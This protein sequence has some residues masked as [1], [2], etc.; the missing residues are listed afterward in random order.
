MNI[1][2]VLVPLDYSACSMGVVRQASGLAQKLGAQVTLLHVAELPPGVTTATPV[3]PHGA[4]ASVGEVLQRDADAHLLRV[5]AAVRA[6]GVDCLA[7]VRFGAV[8]RVILGTADELGVDL[9]VLGTHGRTGLARLVLG[10]VA[11]SVAR[12]ANVP[13]M[14]VRRQP[15]LACAQ[16]NCAWCGVD[17]R[18]A[19]EDRI[20]A[21]TEG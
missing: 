18:S 21:E 7:L 5:V 4:D 2:R 6:D 11:E 19:V 15:G 1:R 8:V 17:G 12:E 16:V 10:S 20:A 13:V 9:I 14:L 3:H